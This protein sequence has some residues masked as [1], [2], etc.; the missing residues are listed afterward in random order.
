M[1]IAQPHYALWA[2]P[3]ETA[4]TSASEVARLQGGRP[5]AVFYPFGHPILYAYVGEGAGGV[6]L[7]RPHEGNHEIDWDSLIPGA[8]TK[9]ATVTQ[10]RSIMGLILDSVS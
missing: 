8:N 1:P 2:G 9:Q 7:T 3:P 5:V 4:L 10:N 6:A